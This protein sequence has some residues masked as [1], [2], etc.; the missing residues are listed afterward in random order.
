MTY[1]RKHEIGMVVVLG[2]IAHLLAYLS[3]LNSGAVV[4]IMGLAVF[5]YLYFS[6][7]KNGAAGETRIL[8][9]ALSFAVLATLVG[10]RE[11][12]K[13]TIINISVALVLIVWLNY[14]N[15]NSPPNTPQ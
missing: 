3:G 14:L 12:F 8:N 15:K 13:S 5:W 7:I 2:V 4:L 6:E 1:L 9:F 10:I 11:V